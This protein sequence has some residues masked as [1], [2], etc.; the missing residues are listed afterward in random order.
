MN[1]AGLIVIVAVLVTLLVVVTLAVGLWI[2][3][4]AWPW[5]VMR[6][7]YVDSLLLAVL[8][9]PAM[10]AF[11][12]ALTRIGRLSWDDA[13]W[14]T[15]A[16]ASGIGVAVSMWHLG[17][18]SARAGPVL[19]DLGL[20]RSPWS[21]A[22]MAIW[23]PC[24]FVLCPQAPATKLFC[25]VVGGLPTSLAMLYGSQTGVRVCENGL[26]TYTTLRSWDS[27]EYADWVPG[28]PREGDG[29]LRLRLRRRSFLAPSGWSAVPMDAQLLPEVQAALLAHGVTIKATE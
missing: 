4:R 8:Y 21:L 7:G 24:M 13:F 14:V 29:T 19:I 27:I 26:W 16:L 25:L 28:G 6:R 11:W 20:M 2:A 12:L 18:S 17:R 15:L 3:R 9:V 1:Q 5:E 23:A 10:G 22:Y